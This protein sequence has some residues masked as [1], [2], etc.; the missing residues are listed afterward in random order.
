MTRERFVPKQELPAASHTE[1]DEPKVDEAAHLAPGTPASAAPDPVVLKKI[2]ASLHDLY[3][4]VPR[5]ALPIYFGPLLG[6]LYLTPTLS[7]RSA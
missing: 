1:L 3:D 5:S 7:R 4:G 6:E 2:G